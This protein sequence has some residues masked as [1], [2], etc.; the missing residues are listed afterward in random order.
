[1]KIK[2]IRAFEILVLVLAAY[3]IVSTEIKAKPNPHSALLFPPKDLKYFSFGFGETVA[4]ILWLRDIQDFE[5]CGSVAE[6]AKVKGS[7]ASAAACQKGW[8]YRMLDMIT[9]LAPRF[10]MPYFSGATVLSIIAKDNEG[11]SLIFKRGVERFPNDWELAYRAGYHFMEAMRDDA[12]AS[13]Y[14]LLAARKG[15]PGWVFSLA[16]KL[17]TKI[18][19]ALLAKSVLEQVIREDPEGRWA[20]TYEKRLD[21]INETLSKG[22]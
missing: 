11:A 1:M 16:A 17:K 8:S 15:A 20:K 13:E 19:Q 22:E 5:L 9:E 10:R 21:E 4:D 2:I 12:T 7:P 6:F 14:L 18:G 3:L